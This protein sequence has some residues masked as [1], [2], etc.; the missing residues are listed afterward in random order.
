MKRLFIDSVDRL[1]HVVAEERKASG[2]TQAEL[3]RRAEVSRR[4][5]IEVEKGH[6]R[7][8]LDKVLALLH[9]LNIRP[10]ALPPVVPSAEPGEIDL[11]EHLARYSRGR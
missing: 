10:Y 1:A 6:P 5:V 7:A 2:I 11:D 9:A 3:A 8:E 4:F